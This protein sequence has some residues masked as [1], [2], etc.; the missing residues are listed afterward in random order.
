MNETQIRYGI[1]QHVSYMNEAK[2][3]RQRVTQRRGTC[4]GYTGEN[5]PYNTETLLIGIAYVC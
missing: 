1:C 2:T 3:E 4:R 5:V